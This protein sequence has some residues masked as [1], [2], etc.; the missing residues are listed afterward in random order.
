VERVQVVTLWKSISTDYKQ[1]HVI[2][3]LIGVAGDVLTC[4]PSIRKVF[5]AADLSVGPVVRSAGR[6][7]GRAYLLR[8]AET[9]V[10]RDP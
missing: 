6:L 5:G 8:T 1:Y 4:T 9:L 7:A 3:R 2:S 10:G